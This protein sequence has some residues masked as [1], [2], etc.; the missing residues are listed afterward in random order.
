[1][2]YP[3]DQNILEPQGYP[4]TRFF[5][6]H[7]FDGQQWQ[8]NCL[9]SVDE[10]GLIKTLETDATSAL[11]CTLLEGYTLPMMPNVHSHAFQRSMAGRAEKITGRQND[12]FWTWRNTMYECASRFTPEDNYKTACFV[13]EEM[14]RAG[15]NWVGEF[16]YL[17]HA[18]D[19]VA[20]DNPFAMTDALIAAAADTGIGMTILPALY[21]Y[22]G[23][24]GHPPTDGQRR[25]IHNTDSY[26]ALID[27]CLKE[28]RKN[29]LLEVGL[30]FH[31]LRA[32]SAE[33]RQ[34]L[35]AAY[36]DLPIHIHV[37]E[38]VKEVEDCLSYCDRRPVEHLFDT[39]DMDSRW[40]LIHATH[41]NAQEIKMIADSGAVA[42]L[43]PMTE[44]N[45]GDGL[46]PLADFMVHN[47]RLAI[48]SDSH[49][50]IN[51]CEELRLLEYGQRLTTQ[52]RSISAT[53]ESPSPALTLY[54]AALM[55]GARSM[56]AVIGHLTVGKSADFIVLD[57][58]AACFYAARDISDVLDCYIFAGNP[59]AIKD[60]YT[61]GQPL[62]L[63]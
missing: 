34:K 7:L 11:G 21:S 55:G 37:A 36:P 23:F 54:K 31:S 42:G 20:Y 44:A 30:C 1:M 8:D 35:T 60:I 3:I 62:R 61:G 28:A 24:G 10:S 13:Y 4:M 38:Q 57:K 26:A 17:Y 25:F 40:T 47:G 51:P 39:C 45:L 12:S 56:N 46:F 14:L 32:T 41:L 2:L 16:Q 22:S 15:Y 48:G 59:T 18:T 63:A 5:A 52:R 27:H 43:C 6:K 53:P 9:I 19:G 49:I 29:P 33:Q 58:N 50:A